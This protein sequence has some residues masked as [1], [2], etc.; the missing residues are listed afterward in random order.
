MD[1]HLDAIFL[2]RSDGER[3]SCCACKLMIC[4]EDDD[5]DDD[6]DADDADEVEEGGLG[7]ASAEVKPTVHERM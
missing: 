2:I 7:R 3:I 1:S 6:D 5:D 4:S